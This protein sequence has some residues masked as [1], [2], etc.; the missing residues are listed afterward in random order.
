MRISGKYRLRTLFLLILFCSVLFA[1]VGSYFVYARQESLLVMDIVTSG[2][3]IT[4]SDPL[5][6]NSFG[7]SIERICG[8]YSYHH[9]VRARIVE[10][11]H[12]SRIRY[13]EDLQYLDL[14][15]SAITDADLV[16]IPGL[17]DLRYLNLRDCKI[18]DDGVRHLMRL[19]NLKR[20][21]LRDTLVSRTGRE[22]LR[23]ALPNIK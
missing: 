1:W 7:E 13:F 11:N 19:K 3:S 4:N 12:L 22:E 15:S 17:S 8:P 2:G 6:E 10:P 9:V 16:H 21:N 20:L 18:T 23:T 14:S 5:R